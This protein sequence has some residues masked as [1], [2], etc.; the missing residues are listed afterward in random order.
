M[1]DG[2]VP[3]RVKAAYG[4]GSV[5]YGASATAAGLFMLF[6]NQVLG[7]PASTA[8]GMIL[9]SL[10]IDAIFDLVIGRWSDR[11]KSRLGRRHPFM[12]AAALPTALFFYLL[13]HS[14]RNLPLASLVLVMVA[15]MM[16][17]RISVSLYEI[18]SSALTPELTSDFDD[19]T[20][21]QAWRWLFLLIGLT[22]SSLLLNE[23]FLGGAK[24]GVLFREG[25]E[26]WSVAIVGVIVASI[27]I[28]ALGTQKRVLEN[29]APPAPSGTLAEQ[30]RQIRLTLMNPSLG[31]LI[32]AG[33]I[34][35]VATGM[36]A[37]LNV[38]IWTHVWSL[39]PRQ[40]GWIAPMTGLGS[41]V[42]V[43][44]APVLGKRFGK[45]R[46]MIAIFVASVAM[47]AG[48]L[49]LRLIGV[50]PPNGSPLILP[51]LMLDAA[52]AATLGIVG[53][54]MAA[55]MTADI[56]EDAAVRSGAR[57]EGLLYAVQGLIGKFAG[58]I[59]AFAA[60]VML[61]IVHFPSHALRGSVD[62]AIVRH[63]I[64]IYLPA[65]VVLNL[66]AI[67]SLGLYRIDR[68][69]HERNLQTLRDAAALA[70]ETH[71][72]ESASS[73]EAPTPSFRPL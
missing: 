28:S 62:P 63:L 70:E 49:F 1:A 59:G 64:E 73:G 66:I 56:V 36:T 23:V 19:R 18:A 48:P 16:A 71:I 39:T 6:L 17:T 42:A 67:A 4:F 68:A 2:R 11:L 47:T 8:G 26:N 46:T 51:I 12:Y 33:V 7:I 29:P 61:T 32:L 60:G 69:T 58:G 65:S 50:M 10:V 20:S 3:V 5:A 41:V 53:Y 30:A 37:N 45:K 24:S 31:A 43:V 25:Y 55:S 9:A 34:G 13:W 35:G 72:V 14:P 21:L 15:I 40:F 54:I 57:S 27:L 52:L 44:L 38:Y 22:G